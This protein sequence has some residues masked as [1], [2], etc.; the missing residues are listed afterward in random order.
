[1]DNITEVL[2]KLGEHFMNTEK[3][4]MKRYRKT[5]I[6]D[7]L[8][9]MCV[10]QTLNLSIESSM[11]HV[12]L[13]HKKNIGKKKSYFDRLD[14]IDTV[15]L[16]ESIAYLL[17]LIKDVESKKYIKQEL[18]EL[19]RIHEKN[20]AVDGTIIYMSEKIKFENKDQKFSLSQNGVCLKA[21]V[22]AI[23]DV[24]N[25]MPIDYAIGDND[26]R[27][28]LESQID[29][30]ILKENDTVIHDRG[31][32][33]GKLLKKYADKNIHCL[34]R[35]KKSNNICRTLNKKKNSYVANITYSKQKIP[36]RVMYY[37]VEGSE[38]GYYLLTNNTDTT[39]PVSEYKDMYKKRWNI[40]THF[41]QVKTNTKF[42]N[43]DI[44]TFKNYLK[45][46]LINNLIFILTSY[47]IK[48]LSSEYLNPDYKYN[49]KNAMRIISDDI[50]NLVLKFPEQINASDMETI[51]GQIKT[52]KIQIRDE[53][54]NYPRIKKLPTSKWTASGSKTSYYKNNIAIQ[55]I[56][57]NVTPTE[58][59]NNVNSITKNKK[60]VTSITKNKKNDV[61]DDVLNLLKKIIE[62]TI[63]FYVR[64]YY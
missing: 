9:I 42:V 52:N 7:V 26:E 32:F 55:E 59:V 10:S 50:M 57:N 43:T 13:K 35:M 2:N 45:N 49:Q 36:V 44:K 48:E 64:T 20:F 46:I 22:S 16:K 63:N 61:E 38:N 62:H 60:N 19:N 21:L 24:D 12:I 41:S 40:E 58:K 15:I 51:I 31:Y 47:I 30:N 14:T 39:I 8:Q 29:K 56:K 6:R 33:S 11:S 3:K 28:L 34:F 27:K 4:I 54:T 53:K 18:H 23:Y 25:K 37:E 5:T 1:M 17:S